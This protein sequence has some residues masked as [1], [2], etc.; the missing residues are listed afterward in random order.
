MPQQNSFAP[1]SIVAHR[2]FINNFATRNE[3][4]CKLLIDKIS[5]PSSDACLSRLG[6]IKIDITGTFVNKNSGA[7][8]V[9]KHS[10]LTPTL[11][12][13]LPITQ[14]FC[15]LS[16]VPYSHLVIYYSRHF[17]VTPHAILL[18]QKQLNVFTPKWRLWPAVFIHVG[19][20]RCSTP[21]GSR[22]HGLQ[23]YD[24]CATDCFD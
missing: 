13:V 11:N 4:S 12:E 17:S 16:L 7:F 18:L 21:Q 8:F 10:T 9:V 22:C 19:L 1:L 5:S 24:P 2:R 14:F 15:I 6:K 3:I 20:A 23:D